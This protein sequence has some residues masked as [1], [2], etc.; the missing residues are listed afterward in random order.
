M[1]RALPT[2][3]GALALLLHLGFEAFA[4]DGEAE[5]ARHLFLLVERQAVGV[6]ELEGGRARK[7]AAL[8]RDFASSWKTLLGD[9]ERGG[10]AMLL[11]LHDAAT[12]WTLS[13]SS[14]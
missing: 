4:I 7:D 13:I 8:R 10:V 9:L 1:S 3:A 12:R 2:G 5:L 14:G 11:V 6:V